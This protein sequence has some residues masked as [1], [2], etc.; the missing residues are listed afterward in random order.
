MGSQPLDA[1]H[2]RINIGAAVEGRQPEVALARSPEAAAGGAD[3]IG[4]VEQMIEEAPGVHA[5][6]GLDPD[7]G[8]MFAAVD[9]ES[10]SC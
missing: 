2:G 10:C 4:F 8:S 6:G 1:R 9:G 7:V 5:V 3:H